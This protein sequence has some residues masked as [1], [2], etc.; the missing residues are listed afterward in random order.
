[1]TLYP[2]GKKSPLLQRELTSLKP[3]QNFYIKFPYQSW[4][5]HGNRISCWR[6]L[7]YTMWEL[8]KQSLQ[9]SFLHDWCYS[10]KSTG[11]QLLK[12][13]H[14]QARTHVNELEPHID[15]L[16]LMYILISPA[17]IEESILQKSG[18]FI[19]EIHTH[20]HTTHNP[21]KLKEDAAGGTAII[22]LAASSHWWGESDQQQCVKA[23]KWIL[24]LFHP[25]PTPPRIS[26]VTYT[27]C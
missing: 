8:V 4:F 19:T 22:G 6:K 1:M 23:I 11:R 17:N 16:K 20:I 7:A 14:K 5:N 13:D 2:M 27:N 10:L 3:L 25:I 12:E 9:G 18:P 26:L 24:F 15:G 21:K